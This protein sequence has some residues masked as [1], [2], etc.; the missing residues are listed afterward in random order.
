VERAKVSGRIVSGD[1]A[2][3]QVNFSW[4]YLHGSGRDFLIQAVLE[5][6]KWRGGLPDSP[7]FINGFNCGEADRRGFGELFAISF[8]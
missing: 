6:L 3:E 8:I 1:K 5:P 4:K 7:L 2:H